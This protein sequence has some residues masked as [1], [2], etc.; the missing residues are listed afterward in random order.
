MNSLLYCLYDE[1]DYDYRFTYTFES[2]EGRMH[3]QTFA[4]QRY[5]WC[6][7]DYHLVTRKNIWFHE[8]KNLCANN[9]LYVRSIII[10]DCKLLSFWFCLHLY[11]S[12]HVYLNVSLQTTPPRPL[13]LCYSEKCSVSFSMVSLMQHWAY[14]IW[15]W[16]GAYYVI[17]PQML[18]TSFCS[19]QLSA[20]LLLCCS[21][22]IPR[23]ARPTIS[24][25]QV[26]TGLIIGSPQFHA[27]LC[28]LERH[29]E[30]A[31]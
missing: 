29:E 24:S 10:V 16:T 4:V 26:S 6:P 28:C 21:K 19:K 20:S 9:M 3:K 12:L 17:I 25:H 11:A 23:Q 30:R 13:P 8:S 1:S 14:G 5:C 2:V 18:A 31:A 27:I 22:W 7:L 15:L